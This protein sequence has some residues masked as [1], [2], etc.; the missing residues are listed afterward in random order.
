MVATS[1][2]QFTRLLQGQVWA[3]QPAEL[4]VLGHSDAKRTRKAA[5]RARGGTTRCTAKSGTRPHVRFRFRGY[6][7]RGSTLLRD[8]L[9]ASPCNVALAGASDS[10]RM[11]LTQTLA[12]S[13]EPPGVNY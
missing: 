8:G 4:L 11:S 3:A 6:A 2:L 10:R 13:R 12:L 1:D 9:T 5:S 7:S